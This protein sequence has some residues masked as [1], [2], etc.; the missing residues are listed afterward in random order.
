MFSEV[1]CIISGKVQRVG[2]RDFVA[3]AAKEH[4]LVGY[5]KNR[6]DGDV[7][8]LAQGLPDELK[9][10]IEELY[11]GSVLADVASV[12]ADWRTP[13]KQYDDFEVTV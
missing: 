12:G 4:G 11:E 5:V 2:Y 3:K 13:K 7:E 9:L 1:F 6:E 10:F 8:V